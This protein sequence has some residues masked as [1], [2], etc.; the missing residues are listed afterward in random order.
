MFISKSFF[1]FFSLRKSYCRV[2]KESQ[3]VCRGKLKL[4]DQF[5]LGGGGGGGGEGIV[6]FFAIFLGGTWDTS[7]STKILLLF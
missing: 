2:E 6:G 1:F 3:K 7:F 4:L 5:F